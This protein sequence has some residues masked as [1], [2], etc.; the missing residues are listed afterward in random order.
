MKTLTRSKRPNNRLG[1]WTS[2]SGLRNAKSLFKSPTPVPQ[3]ADAASL[4][5]THKPSQPRHPLASY[6]LPPATAISPATTSNKRKLEASGAIPDAPAKRRQVTD[7]TDMHWDE[8]LVT[9]EQ[10]EQFYPHIEK[11][12]AEIEFL[13]PKN[14]R[15]LPLRLRRLFGRI[16]L[17]KMEY[18]LLRGIFSRVQALNN[19]T[20]KSSKPKEDQN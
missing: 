8:P 5:N 6:M 1:Q 18:H 19:G 20:W 13:D 12:L 4:A 3:N 15:L 11:M 17:D 16:Q 14:P 2:P 10:M 9:H 7:S